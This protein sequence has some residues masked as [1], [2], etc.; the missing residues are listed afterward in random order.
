MSLARFTVLLRTVYSFDES[1]MLHIIN[2]LNG[3]SYGQ[4]VLADRT[5]QIEQ[6]IRNS[7]YMSALDMLKKII[8]ELLLEGDDNA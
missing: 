3:C 2:D 6:K 7:D 4:V 5:G 8:D 1:N